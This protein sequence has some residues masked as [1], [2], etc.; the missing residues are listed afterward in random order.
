MKKMLLLS[1]IFALCASAV[2]SEEVSMKQNEEVAVES[3]KDM[4]FG[5]Q[6][7]YGLDNLKVGFGGR[8]EKDLAQI[9]P[10]LFM[11]AN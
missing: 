1:A 9:K 7:L 3:A 8:F 10:D 2:F 11:A 6:L 5:G 4:R